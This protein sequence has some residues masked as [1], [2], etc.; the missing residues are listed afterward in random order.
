MYFTLKAIVNVFFQF[1]HGMHPLHLLG[2]GGQANDHPYS[3]GVENFGNVG[4]PPC[5]K[6]TSTYVFWWGLK[7]Q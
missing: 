1:H 4:R 5:S 7:C 3:L 6:E 2:G